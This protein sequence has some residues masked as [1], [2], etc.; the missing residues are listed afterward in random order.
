VIIRKENTRMTKSRDYKRNR[1]L[2][3]YIFSK[4]TSIYI[5]FKT[6]I[7][8]RASLFIFDLTDYKILLF[9]GS[10]THTLIYAIKVILLMQMLKG[11]ISE[12]KIWMKFHLKSDLS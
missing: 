10:S 7:R 8:F 6:L 4:A 3:F 5:L 11:E 1:S 9:Y 12:N 2:Y